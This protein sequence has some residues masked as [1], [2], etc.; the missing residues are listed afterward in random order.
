MKF[1]KKPSTLLIFWL[2]S[3]TC[4]NFFMREENTIFPKIVEWLY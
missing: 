4:I 2:P 3:V 1:I